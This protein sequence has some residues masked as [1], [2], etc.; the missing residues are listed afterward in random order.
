MIA[1]REHVS[2]S[3]ELK[4]NDK[5]AELNEIANDVSSSKELKDQGEEGVKE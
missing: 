3:K 1:R 2:S 5:D 4:G